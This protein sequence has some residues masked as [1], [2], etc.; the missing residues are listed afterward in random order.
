[1]P[2]TEL[3]DLSWKHMTRAEGRMCST[4]PGTQTTRLW[5]LQVFV[6]FF[7]EVIFPKQLNLPASQLL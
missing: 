7:N 4:L 5:C 6:G 1:M 2:P 3:G